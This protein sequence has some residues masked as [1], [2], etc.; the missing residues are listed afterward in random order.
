MEETDM[1]VVVS[2]SQ[3]E[4][5]GMKAKGLDIVSHR[6]RMVSEDLESKFKDPDDPFRIVFVCAMWL[7]GFDAPSCSTLY[8]GGERLWFLCPHCGKRVAVLYGSGA[9]FLC[10]HCYTLPYGCQ[11]KTYMD[12]MMRKARKIRAH[13]GASESLMEPWFGLQDFGA[14]LRF[15]STNRPA[16]LSFRP[17]AALRNGL[18][19]ATMRPFPC[20]AGRGK[21]CAI[22]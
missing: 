16:C 2:S 11:N 17:P 7:T 14:G 9:R 18:H 21:S 1:A 4:I 8:H 12:R 6:K 10:R 5:E 15:L 13:L 20:L 3:N 19:S 22:W